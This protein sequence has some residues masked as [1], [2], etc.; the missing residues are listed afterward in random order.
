MMIQLLK[1]KHS[2]SNVDIDIILY[3]Y[4]LTLHENKFSPFHVKDLG[5]GYCELSAADKKS[6]QVVSK[7]DT[8][9]AYKADADISVS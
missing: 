7:V 5:T 4:I 1:Q 6:A 9:R 8:D 2:C 3:P